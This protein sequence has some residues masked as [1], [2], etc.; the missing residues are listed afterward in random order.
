MAEDYIDPPKRKHWKP[1]KRCL[2]AFAIE[3]RICPVAGCEGSRSGSTEV[4]IA[5]DDLRQ[6]R[7][8]YRS[9][10]IQITRLRQAVR[11]II[12]SL[13]AMDVGALSTADKRR[14]PLARDLARRLASIP[15]LED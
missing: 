8:A 7:K 9:G 15:D 1:S 13:D 5:F 14:L 4:E 10:E 3:E 2:H 6:L 12:E 11:P